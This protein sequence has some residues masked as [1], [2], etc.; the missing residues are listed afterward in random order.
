MST[1][2]SI[3]RNTIRVDGHL[4]RAIADARKAQ[5][6]AD[7]LFGNS[8]AASTASSQLARA[9][10]QAS[11]IQAFSR[12]SYGA[13]KRGLAIGPAA[14][15]LRET[16]GSQLIARSIA[17]QFLPAIQMQ[18]QLARIAV[19]TSRIANV[20]T[21]LT[22]HVHG[23]NTLPSTARMLNISHGPDFTSA[24][25]RIAQLMAPMQAAAAWVARIP[26]LVIQAEA[27]LDAYVR[28]D[29][30]PMFDFIRTCL[31]LRRPTDDH[32]QA[33]ALALFAQ[34]WKDTTDLRDPRAVRLALH[35][36]AAAGE[37]WE[38]NHQVAGYKIA[39]LEDLQAKEVR[40]PPSH[41]AG[42]EET[43]VKELVSWVDSFDSRH[44]VN[45]VRR[46]GEPEMAV[47]RTWAEETFP[48]WSEA[49]L[50][51]RQEPRFANR[52]KRKLRREGKEITRRLNILRSQEEQ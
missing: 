7:A 14:G 33:L 23:L 38:A 44:V 26:W 30:E 15:F 28:G 31:G 3:Q 52:M 1:I 13:L 51:H 4:H 18:S 32:A 45:V 24:L 29:R 21:A 12:D 37:V 10:R 17:K 5:A 42:P 39:S 22:R 46:L 36:L 16:A 49:V 9:A 27:A 25:D 34:D 41:A 40:L 6:R 48:D 35:K 8:V 50:L 2:L 20:H 43:V 19:E 47:T 11:D